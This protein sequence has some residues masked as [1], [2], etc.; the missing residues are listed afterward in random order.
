MVGV[1]TGLACRNKIPFCGTF[2]AFFSRAADQIRIAGIS[3]SKIKLVGS[4]SGCS[5][6]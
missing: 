5:I 3:G 6:G 4:H 2:A 1:A